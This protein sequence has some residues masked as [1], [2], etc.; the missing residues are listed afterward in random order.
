MQENAEVVQWNFDDVYILAG[1][2]APAYLSFV[3][4]QD[5]RQQATINFVLLPRWFGH[6]LPVALLF[7]K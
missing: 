4:E 1:S 3:Q 5:K 7:D 2:F 6:D